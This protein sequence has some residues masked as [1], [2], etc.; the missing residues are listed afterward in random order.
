MAWI[1]EVVERRPDGTTHTWAMKEL[2]ADSDDTHTLEEGRRLFE[3]EAHILVHLSHPNLPRV[4]AYFVIDGRSYLV[5][6]FIHGESLLKKLEHAQAP[7]L[8]SQVLGWAIQTCDVLDYLHSRPQPIIFRDIKPSN[9]MVTMDGCIKLIDFGIARTYKAGKNRD[10]ITMGSENFAAP[11]Q[12]GKAQTDGRAD[13]YGLGATMY[14]LLTNV[15]PLPAFV[16]TPR[17]PMQQY[18]PAVTDQ[19]VAAVE[20]AMAEN[21]DARHPSALAF[22]KALLNCLPNRERRHLETRLTGM[23]NSQATTRPGAAHAGANVLD[24]EAAA[25]PQRQNKLCPSCGTR[26]RADARFCPHCGHPFVPPLPPV[27]ALIAPQKAHW[28][29]PLHGKS[30]LIGRHGG[31]LPVDLDVSF[32]D[33]EGYASR[34]HACIMANQRRYRIIALE[35]TNG[36]YLNGVQ[37]A[38]SVPQLLRN[39]DRIHLGRVVLEFRVR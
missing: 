6:E 18:N 39:G 13:I 8:E 37:L 25:P 32:Y 35:S 38:P 9:I 5:M 2:R 21:R 1:Y 16:P 33:P 20:K 26:A 22:R 34:N 17:V 36:T 23:R 7:L 31:K 19:T 24:Q 4:S 14:Q 10:T 15:P 27:L 30:I 12:W 29:F 3:Q 11:E 28:E